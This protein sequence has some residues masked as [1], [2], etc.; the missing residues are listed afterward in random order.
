M[1]VNQSRRKL[2]IF[3]MGMTLASPKIFAAQKMSLLEFR[4]NSDSLQVTLPADD[5]HA[6]VFSLAHPDRVVIDVSMTA[7]PGSLTHALVVV[8]QKFSWITSAKSPISRR[9]RP[10]WYCSLIRLQK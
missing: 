8:K 6:R 2:L 9:K 3:G 4:S 5:P 7:F 10:A 1:T